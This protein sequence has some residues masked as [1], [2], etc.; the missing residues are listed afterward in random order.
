[1]G[2]IVEKIRFGQPGMRICCFRFSVSE[3]FS[4]AA[5]FE[6]TA[7]VLVESTSPQKLTE[8]IE[9]FD[10]MLPVV[11]KQSRRARCLFV[12]RMRRLHRQA[13]ML[14]IQSAILKV[15]TSRACK[16]LSSIANISRFL[17]SK[18]LLPRDQSLTRHVN[19]ITAE[20]A[21]LYFFT[22]SPLV[23]LDYKHS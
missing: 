17:F 4:F 22:S 16:S 7:L 13:G 18:E 2:S 6:G 9:Q 15:R 23:Y 12:D 5:A 3:G 8:Y 1:M 21:V 14:F 10:G 20:P 11:G 19:Q